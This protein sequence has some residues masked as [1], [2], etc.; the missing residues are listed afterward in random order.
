MPMDS[1]VTIFCA[2]VTASVAV[3]AKPPAW[4][5]IERAEAAA[6]DLRETVAEMK[7]LVFPRHCGDLFKVGQKASGVYTIFH[8]AAN[9]SG[10]KVYCDMET[11][12][13]GWTVIQR[14]GQFGNNVFYFNRNWEEYATG[15]GD[16]AKEYWIGNRALHTLTS[17]ND[18][19]DL[20]V[21]LSNTTKDSESVNYRGIRIGSEDDLFK[22][23]VGRFLGP[24]G[25]NSLIG[26]NGMKFSTY[27][28]D[29]DRNCA[30]TYNGGWWYSKHYL[31]NLNGLNQNGFFQGSAG[32][33][34]WGLTGSSYKLNYSY[35][36]AVMLIRP[37]EFNN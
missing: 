35:P 32:G 14:R 12:G 7:S 28:K 6:T 11:D 29:N 25:W 30:Q 3:H 27:D 2:L 36:S 5:T 16:P 26:T 31:A 9:S 1:F 15:F 34:V 21:V 24:E 13:G 20:R 8:K 23:D 17:A 33:I 37:T 19:M 4:S 10:Q 22:M 18:I